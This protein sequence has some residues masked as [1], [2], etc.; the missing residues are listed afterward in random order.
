MI[1]KGSDKLILKTEDEEGVETEIVIPSRYEVCERCRGKGTHVNP[2]VD[3]NG[4]GREDFEDDEFAEAY[5]S[6]QYDVPC[7][8]CGGKRVVLVPNEEEATT[9]QL[10]LIEKY[11]D[12]KYEEYKNKRDDEHVRRAENGYRD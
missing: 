6:G 5:W 12:Q 10:A 11:K 3:G 2:S 7:E 4:L 9:E 8:D 1:I